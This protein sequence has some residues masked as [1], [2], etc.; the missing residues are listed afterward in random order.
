MLVKAVP[1]WDSNRLRSKTK[2]G[3]RAQ[4]VWGHVDV[5]SPVLRLRRE[6]CNYR[7]LGTCCSNIGLEYF[8][9]DEAAAC[10]EETLSSGRVSVR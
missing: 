10:Y 6:L 4:S 8:G 9:V 5:F 3:G 1:A 2:A 7:S